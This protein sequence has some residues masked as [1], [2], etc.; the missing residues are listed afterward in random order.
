VHRMLCYAMLCIC[1]A[2]LCL[3][4]AM[5]GIRHVGISPLPYAACASLLSHASR[6][7]SHGHTGDQVTNSTGYDLL[8]HE[9]Q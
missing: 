4:Y 8:G 3:R 9:H 6:S 2:I 7:F 5:L 1:V